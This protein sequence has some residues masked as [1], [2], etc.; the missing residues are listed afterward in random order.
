MCINACVSVTSEDIRKQKLDQ[1]AFF[2]DCLLMKTIGSL[3][4]LQRSAVISGGWMI[5]QSLSQKLCG[6]LVGIFPG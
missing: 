5:P 1:A 3:D 6:A 4:P 2:V